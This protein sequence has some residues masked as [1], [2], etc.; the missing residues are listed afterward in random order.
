ME[1]SKEIPIYIQIQNIIFENVLS[2]KWKE[3][4]K[5]PSV[6]EFASSLEVNPN[7]VQRT[8]LKL[9]ELGVLENKRGI[10]YFIKDKATKIVKDIIKKQFI[11]HQLPK[12]IKT[13]K[14]LEITEEELIDYIKK[15][16]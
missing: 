1:F 3:G 8:F 14:L 9:L 12:L 10:G 13:M 6:R 4:Y 15:I 2:Q 5:I 16:G 7:T 11:E